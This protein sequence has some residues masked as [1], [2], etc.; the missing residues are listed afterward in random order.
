MSVN[1][2]D[3]HPDDTHKGEEPVK[4]TSLELLDPSQRAAVVFD[5]A[6]P[7]LI[8]AGAGSGKTQTMATRVA[9]LI[10]HR[11][12]LPHTVL[13]IVFTRHAAE[14]LRERVK[15]ILLHELHHG[16]LL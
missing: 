15:T 10:S 9:F 14:T 5:P 6:M 7:L 11:Q 2:S 12:V 4:M 1:T 16:K 13:G 8:K 3:N